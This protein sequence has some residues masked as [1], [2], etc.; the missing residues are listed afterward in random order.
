MQVGQQIG[1]F[2]I[3]RELGAG[4]MG[5]VYRGRSTKSGQRV[6]IKVMLPGLDESEPAVK[7]FEREYELL[8]K[9]RHPNIVRFL[10]QGKCEGRQFYAMEYVEGESLDHVLARRKRVSWEEVVALGRQLCAA[11]QHAHLQGIVHRDLKPSNLML[12][13]DGTLKLTDFGIAKLLD[14]TQLT[15]ANCTVG[16]ASYMSP[17]QCKGDRNLTHKSD[18]YSLGVVFYELLTGKKPF[19]ADNVMDMFMAHVKGTFERPG[20]VVLDVPKGLDTLVCQL[21]EKAP[22]KRPF[23]A[24][25][26]GNALERVQ[27][28]AEAQQSAGV[29]AVRSRLIDRQPGDKILTDETDREAARTL[30]GAGKKR[31]KKS[32]AVPLL[33]RTWVKAAGILLLLAA[34][35][36][37]FWLVFKPPSAETLYAK[38]EKRLAADTPEGRRAAFGLVQEYLMRY[39]T[40]DDERTRRVRALD[41]ELGVEKVARDLEDI[42]KKTKLVKIEK[43]DALSK[44]A[45]LAY[46]ASQAE[47][48]GDLTTAARTWQK[49]EQEHNTGEGRYWTALGK[50]HLAN[51]DEVGKKLKDLNGLLTGIHENRDEGLARGKLEGDFTPEAFRALRYERF[52]D[53]FEAR[54]RWAALMEKAQDK[55]EERVWFLLGASKAREVAAALRKARL[56]AVKDETAARLKIVEGRLDAAREEAGRDAASKAAAEAICLDIRALY[57]DGAPKEFADVVRA[58]EKLLGE[59]EKVLPLPK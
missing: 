50:Q 3:E 51:F 12:L 46:D 5:A 8:R 30:L 28:K 38:I 29:D 10:G 22:D 11:L 48:A 25:A 53:L 55:P 45:R 9:C 24:D 58:N 23:D 13:P 57:G 18:L 54:R 37:V 41:Y 27:E 26:V 14:V 6:A 19:Q 43:M 40:R 31:K 33:Q 21:L 44:A 59:L 47:E 2:V 20:R 4:A 36:V 49:I 7:R 34:I 52:G 17:E 42:K 1:P 56:H 32:Q 39:G 35:G 15:S 16:T